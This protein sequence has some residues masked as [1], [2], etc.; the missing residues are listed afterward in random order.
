MPRGP[1]KEHRI[2]KPLPTRR[3]WKRSRGDATW[4]TTSQNPLCWHLSWLS[5]ACVTRKDLESG[6]LVRDSLD[7]NPITIK[8]DTEIHVGEQSSWV[9]LLSCSLPRQPFPTKSLAL[10]ARV[11]P[12]TIHFWE[13]DKSPLSDP[14]RGLLPSSTAVIIHLE[15]C[16][17]VLLQ[18]S[19]NTVGIGKSDNFYEELSNNV[20]ESKLSQLPAREA[21]K[22]RQGTATLFRKLGVWKMV[23]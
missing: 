4:P 5:N 21:N 16:W 7:T 14:G 19:D 8:P 12:Q 13:L 6:C 17:L 23:N 11:S 3:S 9:P 10:S 2:N 18:G 20:N 22:W 1:G 15:T